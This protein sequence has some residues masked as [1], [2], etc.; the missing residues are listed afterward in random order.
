MSEENEIPEEVFF[1][2]ECPK[3]NAQFAVYPNRAEVC[4]FCG[5]EIKKTHRVFLTQTEA[6]KK[7]D[8]AEEDEED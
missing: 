7:E 8:A 2:S 5:H 6:L 3:C 1:Y 4:P